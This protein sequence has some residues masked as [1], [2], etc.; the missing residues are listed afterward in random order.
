M[1]FTRK[2]Y[3][4][5]LLWIINKLTLSPATPRAH[6]KQR[7]HQDH[8]RQPVPR[9]RILQVTVGQCGLERADLR[10]AAGRGRRLLIDVKWRAGVPMLRFSDRRG[11]AGEPEALFRLVWRREAAALFLPAQR[12][13]D[14]DDA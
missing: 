12:T 11:I 6:E 4:R 7:R 9:H 13:R 1:G 8:Q 2:P 5:K 3:R 10:K 14:L